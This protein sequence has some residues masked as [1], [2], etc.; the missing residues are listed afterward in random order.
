MIAAVPIAMGAIAAT[1]AAVASQG[2]WDPRQLPRAEPGRWSEWRPS[3]PI[4]DEHRAALAEGMRAYGA[5][6]YARA[7]DVLFPLLEREPDFP[8]AL[9]QSGTSFFRLRRYGDCAECLERFVAVVPHEIGATQ[10]LGHSLYSLGR[11]EEARS[12]YERVLAAN[13]ESAEALRGYGLAHMRLGDEERALE[14]LRRVVELRPAHAEAHAWIAHLAYEL[15]RLEEAREAAERALELAPHE[16]RPW[17]LL[18]RI[19]AEEGEDAAALE[20]RAR[21]EDLSRIRQEVLA[22][23]G[24]LLHDPTRVEVLRALVDLRVRSRD[25]AGLRRDL[26]LM[27]RLRP[28]DPGVRILALDALLA[29]GDDGAART[30]ALEMER[31]CPSSPEA[32][33]RLQSYWGSVGERMKQVQA[34]ERYLRLQQARAGDGE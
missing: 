19:L 18:S 2:N 10:A 33:K 6:D 23:E 20:A 25:T 5:R 34:G 32:W 17:F 11:Y 4:P 7:L 31:A 24:V 15:D 16:P 30:A 8:P 3:D 14:I 29:A 1:A 21:F 27:T 26:G 12:H 28:G 22:L 9:Y 13:P